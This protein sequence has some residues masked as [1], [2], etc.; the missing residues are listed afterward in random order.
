MTSKLVI[1]VIDA[2]KYNFCQCCHVYGEEKL[3]AVPL[4]TIA[5]STIKSV[6]FCEEC[7]ILMNNA[8]NKTGK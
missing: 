4:V 6:L 2:G 8:L 1:K 5:N 7:I 3:V